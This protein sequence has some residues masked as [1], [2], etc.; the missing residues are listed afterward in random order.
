MLRVI[1]QFGNACLFLK[2]KKKNLIFRKNIVMTF[3]KQK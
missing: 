3:L 2:K 1:N